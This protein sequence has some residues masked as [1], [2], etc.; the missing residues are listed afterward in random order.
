MRIQEILLMMR[1]APLR[2]DRSAAADNSGPA[3]Y[4]ERDVAKQDAGMDG[5]VIDTLLG[6]LDQGVPIHVPGQFFRAAAGLLERL[7]NRNGSNRHRRVAQNPF[8]GFVN[9][10]QLSGADWN[11]SD[12]P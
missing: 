12:L 1:E 10:A 3:L 8:P 6:L 7:V 5:E 2:K 11:R 4:G 9:I